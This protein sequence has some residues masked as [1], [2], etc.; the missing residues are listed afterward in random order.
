MDVPRVANVNPPMKSTT[1]E[2][3]YDYDKQVL[4][5]LPADLQNSIRKLPA[6]SQKIMLNFFAYY[7]SVKRKITSEQLSSVI[8]FITAGG[9]YGGNINSAS[10]ENINIKLKKNRD[11]QKE[12]GF[13]GHFN[14]KSSLLSSKEWTEGLKTLWQKLKSIANHE[15]VVNT[16]NYLELDVASQ[17]M[18]ILPDSNGG[19]R[20]PRVTAR[21]V[22]ARSRSTSQSS[23]SLLVPNNEKPHSV[24]QNSP[25]KDSVV[26][27]DRTPVLQG[28]D[29]IQVTETNDINAGFNAQGQETASFR[30][31]ELH[32]NTAF[33]GPNGEKVYAKKTPQSNTY[34][35][36][37]QRE[38]SEGKNELIPFGSAVEK[39]GIWQR[40][41]LKGGGKPDRADP[42]EEKSPQPSTSK[43][44]NESEENTPTKKQK[45][46]TEKSVD[47]Y[48]VNDAYSG[49]SSD[50]GEFTKRSQKIIDER[51]PVL[52][53]NSNGIMHAKEIHRWHANDIG[54]S[55][56]VDDSMKSIL[57]KY[58]G[59]AFG[60]NHTA[61]SGYD[62]EV[63][64]AAAFM[65]E[66]MKFFSENGV[67]TLYL[68]N[69]PKLQQLE[70]AIRNKDI[71][72]I[73][74]AFAQNNDVDRANII[75]S[76]LENNIDVV[77]V[78]TPVSLN[79]D[80]N[81]GFSRVQKEIVNNTPNAREN[82]LRTY[83]YLVTKE[84][85]MRPNGKWIS[86]SG[87]KHTSAQNN[88]P[89]ISELNKG[90]P[91]SLKYNSAVFKINAGRDDAGRV[92][93][94]T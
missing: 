20:R 79:L 25:L 81:T 47:F 60:E 28:T 91:I 90:F 73:R 76:A 29:K 80:F 19:H 17:S 86:L 69:I 92:I 34:D 10:E 61:T 16:V 32:V 46:E 62:H 74:N 39:N 68:E 51:W 11:T 77:L 88:I 58:N 94:N 42:Q 66:K 56:K 14:N 78:D 33:L 89:G 50:P 1:E 83:N 26:T 31:S 53:E 23:G 13:P 36:V 72:F 45:T 54:T 64:R 6:E 71:V 65:Q 52:L 15:V 35:L 41:G 9:E 30:L 59:I 48:T 55:N 27:K 21:P 67:K 5:K 75:I 37:Y 44:T 22:Q 93:I 4:S 18:S 7:D 12:I 43:R 3:E 40:I 63:H 84:M 57:G 70:S 87:N 24:K 82:R 49:T 2:L 8:K 85:E 38:N